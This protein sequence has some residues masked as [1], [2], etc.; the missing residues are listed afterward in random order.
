LQTHFQERFCVSLGPFH[1]LGSATAHCHR[2]RASKLHIEAAISG[3]TMETKMKAIIA[4][5]ALL[6]L[7][8]GPVFA[9]GA[10]VPQAGYY[11]FS[12]NSPALTGGGSIGHNRLQQAF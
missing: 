6:S 10:Y 5:L 11:G 4:A 12:S 7:A 2:D 3:Q 1:D 9:A 8:A